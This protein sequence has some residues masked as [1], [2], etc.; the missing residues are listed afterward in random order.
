MTEGNYKRVFFAGALCVYRDMF[1]N[2]DIVLMGAIGQT[3]FVAIFLYYFIS[4]PGRI[5]VFFLIPIGGD[6]V[7]LVFFVKFLRFAQRTRSRDS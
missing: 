1:R 2:R 5:P 6:L 4:Y 7:F 3:T